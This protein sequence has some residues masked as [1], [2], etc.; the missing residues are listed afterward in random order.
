[1]PRRQYVPLRLLTLLISIGFAASAFAAPTPLPTKLTQD[2]WVGAKQEVALP[3]GIKMKYVEMGQPDGEALIFLHGMTDNSRSWSLIAPYFTDKY[4][5]FMLDQRGHGETDKPDLRMYPVSLYASDL[6]AFMEAKGIAKANIVGHSLGSMIAQAFAIN[7]PEKTNRVVLESSA[8]VNADTLGRELYDTVVGFGDNPPSDE[9]MAA[10]Y[11]NP[12]PVDQDFLKREM[13]E[14]QS[15]PPYAWRAITKGARASDLTPFM[16]EL[17]A[18]TLIVWGGADGF[19]NAEVQGALKKAIPQ[20]EFIA[21]S[22][23]GHNIQWEIPEKMAADVRKFL[24]AR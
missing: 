16:D 21:Y 12:N 15:I 22:Q 4:H 18:P 3:T 7:Y 8:L 9:F 17:K 24:E 6:A 10:W 11:E 23:A 19:F 5:V 2:E 20:A 14:S 1:M 13:A